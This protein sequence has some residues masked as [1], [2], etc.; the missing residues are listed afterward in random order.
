MQD[1]IEQK[2]LFIVFK[3]R[4]QK[5]NFHK[6]SNT[7]I[8]FNCHIKKAA[9]TKKQTAKRLKTNNGKWRHES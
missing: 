3:L 2:I 1:H 7:Y 4:Q 5:N 8:C 9:E 6:Q